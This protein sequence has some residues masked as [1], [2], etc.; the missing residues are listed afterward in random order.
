ML[1]KIEY[2]PNTMIFIWDYDNLIEKKIKK[3]Y[4]DQF[5][6]DKILNMKLEEDNLEVRII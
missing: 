5:K 4:D 1:V 6:T 3:H 2:H